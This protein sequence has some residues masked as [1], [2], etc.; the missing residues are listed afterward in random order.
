MAEDVPLA[1]WK[2][3]EAARAR[4]LAK[5]Q[6][7]GDFIASLIRYAEECENDAVLLERQRAELH[8]T[9][10]RSRTLSGEIRQLSDEAQ[11]QLAE[12]RRKLDG[13]AFGFPAQTRPEMDAFRC[14]ECAEVTLRS[15]EK[16]L[17]CPVCG[18]RHSIVV[19]GGRSGRA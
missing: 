15:P 17:E 14:L 4:R 13:A 18:S 7:D 2:R 1:T 16:A 8:Q 10:D 12:I 19:E 11:H 5:S 9:V 3:L 6:T